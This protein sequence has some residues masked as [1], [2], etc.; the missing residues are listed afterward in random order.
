MSPHDNVEPEKQSRRSWFRSI[1]TRLIVFFTL[2]FVVVLV[3]VES[4][5]IVGIPF[6]SYSGRRGEQKVEAL[7]GL[8][9]IADLKRERLYRW[10]EG[11]RDNAHVCATNDIVEENVAQLRDA[12]DRFAAGARS[13]EKVWQRVREEGPFRKL[14]RFLR[15]IKRSYGV[16]DEIQIVDTATRRVLVSTDETPVGDDVSDQTY[17]VG[18]MWSHQPYV[19]PVILGGESSTPILHFIHMIHKREVGPEIIEEQEDEPIAILVMK[20]HTDD[21]IKHI[22]HTGAG[23]GK[24]GEA[25]LVDREGWILTSLKHRLPD[26]TVPRPLEH[27]ITAQPAALAASGE[28]GIIDSLDYRGESVLAAY[29]HI[30]VTPESGWGLVVKRDQAELFAPLRADIAYTLVLGS[31]GALAFIGLTLILAGSLTRPIRSLSQTAEKVT[32]GDFS[33]RGPV[34]TSDEVGLLTTTFNTMVDRVENW[35][36][37]LRGQVQDRTRALESHARQQEIVAELGRFALQSD[38]LTDLMNEVAGRMAE[39]LGVEYCEVLEL[40]PDAQALLRAGVGW[41]EGLV[42]R[43]TVPTEQDSQTGY[44][45]L[46]EGPVIVEDLS[47]EDRFS[48]PPLLHDHG[49]VS[50]MSAIIQGPQRPWGVLGAH[51]TRHKIFSKDDVNFLQAVANLLADA[52]ARKHV[53]EELATSETNYH[54]VFNAANDMIVVHDKETGAVLDVNDTYCRVLGFTRE[55]ARQLVIGDFSLGEPPYTQEAGGRWVRK[56][57]EEGPQLFEWVCKKKSGGP[58][59][60]EVNLK[61]AVI[62][63]EDRVLAV[64]R[65]I[66]ERKLAEDALSK[67]ERKYRVLFERTADAT[68]VIDQ[69]R[70]VDCNDAVVKLLRYRNKVDLLGTHPSELSPE[71]QPDGRSSCEKAD[72]MMAIAFKNGSHRFEWDHKR[73]DGEVFPVEVLLTA[74][75]SEDRRILHVVWRDITDRK[76]AEEEREDLIMKLEVQNAELER[77]TYTVSHDLKSPLIT[78]KGYMGVLKE[79]L[80]AGDGERIEDDV[81][82]MASAADKMA[83]LLNELLELSRIGRVVKAPEDVALGEIA[84]EAVELVGGR[85]TQAAVRVEIAPDMPIIFGDRHRLVEVL[86][87]LIENAVK[88]TAGRP[89]P[90]IEIGA[91]KDNREIV[92][93]VRDNGTGI[94]PRHHEKVFGLFEKLD[95]RSEG[96]GVGLALVKRI[97][98]VQGGRIW[99]E[100]KG[101]GQGSTLCFTLPQRT[102]STQRGEI[103]K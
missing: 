57:V 26:G 94:D 22:L 70:F 67:S 31:I 63:G 37:E 20:V 72:E 88:W 89:D 103:A 66:S 60:V 19:G 56:A 98:E 87:N 39:T 85:I 25:L 21:I 29:R 48:G 71:T 99:V 101:V 17:H 44:T 82:R 4:A 27:K 46:F 18:P 2:G 34:T 1:R 11:R 64:V 5:G 100:S 47:T 91:R 54:E 7:R 69:N 95:P 23:L 10:L 15:T 14:V 43:A 97:I 8:D 62:G 53:E 42:G 59:W 93:Y 33:A 13:D 3:L 41:N 75:P 58:F 86:Q 68:L 36:T 90:R 81:T 6:T 78:L 35:H 49:V 9:L 61:L 28:E 83:R 80:A 51:A 84:R 73:A 38:D 74:V 96:S 76:R 102:D 32:A 52:I 40:L 24:S 50:G 30:R 65:D 16:Y 77:F 92:C 12:A 45:L 55:E 79:D